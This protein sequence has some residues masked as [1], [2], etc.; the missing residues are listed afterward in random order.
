VGI[1]LRDGAKA[2]NITRIITEINDRIVRKAVEF[3]V[4]R[5]GPAPLP[6]CW[7]SFGSEGRKEQTFRT[8]QDNALLWADPSTPRRRRP[9]APGSPP[10][11]AT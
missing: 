7:L 8:D 1:L 10:S 3:G 6:W 5:L 2:S 4:H 11:P 9:R